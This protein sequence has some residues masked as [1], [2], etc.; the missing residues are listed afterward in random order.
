[1]T[2]D[3]V[4]SDLILSSPEFQK[5]MPEMYKTHY[6]QRGSRCSYIE[7]SNG[8][9]EYNSQQIRS[10]P[11]L[12]KHKAD[13]QSIS[14][15]A[16]NPV[17][18]ISGVHQGID[19]S[20]KTLT[21]DTYFSIYTSLFS[22]N[23]PDQKE[24][25]LLIP[26]LRFIGNNYIIFEMPPTQ[27]VIDYK[28]AYREDDSPLDRQCYI[29]IPW[30]IYIAIYDPATMRLLS[31]QMYFTNTPLT[32]FN[33]TIYLPPILNFYASGALCRPFF[34][35]IED[36]EKY[37]QNITGIFASA[38]DWVWNSG[39]NFD[40][41]EPISEFICSSK[42]DDFLN[43][44]PDT[45][46]NIFLKNNLKKV[47]FSSN[48]LS[49][50]YVRSF[51]LLWQQ[52]SLYEVTNLKWTSFSIDTDFFNGVSSENY[53]QEL[54]EN[55]LTVHNIILVDEYDE[56]HDP[57]EDNYIVYDDVL[58]NY[59]YRRSLHNKTVSTERN[60]LDALKVS[61]RFMSSNR[62]SKQIFEN[63]ISFRLLMNNI[64]SKIPC[65]V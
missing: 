19:F 51:F 27:K 50:L 8:H 38:Y 55:F 13:E 20:Q 28:E 63:T 61:E 64:L 14:N 25:E 44:I 45:E 30:Q 57:D 12:I 41:V 16:I 60:L 6:N 35:T 15:Q 48:R 42:F 3:T 7:F 23:T 53:D 26:G 62:I 10:W 34:E 17:Q 59:T 11:D 52:L 22:K 43:L 49:P 36:I 56:Y 2:V 4:F 5:A 58:Q 33:Q 9:Y 32:S 1:M 40:I 31:V 47:T 29:P 46:E 65:M 24:L 37:P 39:Y 54:F 18:T 21:I